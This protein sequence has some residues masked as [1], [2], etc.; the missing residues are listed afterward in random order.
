MALPAMGVV[1]ETDRWLP[2]KPP[3]TLQTATIHG[4]KNEF[5][6]FQVAIRGPCTVTS[7]RVAPF[8]PF[9]SQ[10]IRIYRHGTIPCSS[11]SSSD[12]VNSTLIPDVLIPD[13]DDVIG[14]QRNTF[15]FSIA[16]D[17]TNLVWI[18]IHIPPN[19]AAGT[20]SGDCVI[21]IANEG[22]ASFAISLTV[23]DF[24][25]P[26][27][28]SL[29][30]LFKLTYPIL[31]AQHPSA[32]ATQ[33]GKNI[34]T[35]Y[36]C[37][38]ALDH[39]L[40]VSSID[41]GESS[42]ASF[43]RY[44][45]PFLA[46][47]PTNS[48]R[49][50]GAKW[51][52]YW[53]VM[54]PAAKLAPW[55]VSKGTEY[56]EKYLNV[57]CDEPPAT[58]SWGQ[59]PGRHD[60]VHRANSTFRTM[61]TT[62]LQLATQHGVQDSMDVICPLVN[63]IH[64]KTGSRTRSSYDSWLAADPRREIWTYQSCASHGCSKGDDGNPVYNGWT[65]YMLD[66]RD[67]TRASTGLRARMMAWLCWKYQIAG[68]HYYETGEQYVRVRDPWADMYNSAFSG[69]GDGTIYYPG[70]ARRIGGTIDLPLASFR[71]KMIRHGRRAH[72]ANGRA[73]GPAQV[74]STARPGGAGGPSG[75]KSEHAKAPT[76][77]ATT[78]RNR[79]ALGGVLRR[80]RVERLRPPWTDRPGGGRRGARGAAPAAQRKRG[81]GVRRRAPRVAPG[82]PP[83]VR[84]RAAA[85]ASHHLRSRRVPPAGLGTPRDRRRGGAQALARRL[86]RAGVRAARGGPAGAGR[87]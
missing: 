65:S 2:H 36:Y 32:V 13:V 26:S 5:V 14:Q 9:T 70:T 73:D 66:A 25:I 69:C 49:L 39:R 15:P 31:A 46:G 28:S 82:P 59:I 78:T 11:W 34:L 53:P 71:L 30:S 17:T 10:K 84:G 50:S 22:T 48:M 27:T 60:A 54:I 67:S 4:A 63:H 19:A 47:T 29:K 81:A 87:G 79:P 52:A 74:V 64:T 83:A 77:E 58:C 37:Q 38:L 24:S 6:A 18:D 42:T 72:D 86:R 21:S 35:Q 76:P 33:T 51:T 45:G 12:H 8:G 85:A 57:I 75:R 44:F 20:Y 1:T 3:P 61:V 41:T 16:R 23:W 80:D 55:A 56:V 43:D 68:E 40:S 62:N 7:C